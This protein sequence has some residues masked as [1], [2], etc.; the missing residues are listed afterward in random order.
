MLHNYSCI[1]KY[2]FSIDRGYGVVDVQADMDNT[3]IQTVID[4]VYDRIYQNTGLPDYAIRLCFNFIEND[5][6]ADL[7]EDNIIYFVR[8]K[9]KIKIGSS[10]KFFNRLFSLQT[11]NPEPLSC[12]R[13]IKMETK[14][15]MRRLEK[16]LHK[17]Y[18]K[19]NV[20]NEWFTEE[21]LYDI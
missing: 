5:D 18:H 8:C 11:G 1:Y 2:K 19:Y 14:E 17:K 9:D 12:E 16:D 10:C 4:D 20:R 6:N 7:M 13:V 3:D 21:V 15:E